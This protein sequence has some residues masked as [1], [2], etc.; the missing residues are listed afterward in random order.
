[1]ALYARLATEVNGGVLA[2]YAEA[3]RPS[4]TKQAWSYPAPQ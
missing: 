1:M 2:K 4:V 3:G